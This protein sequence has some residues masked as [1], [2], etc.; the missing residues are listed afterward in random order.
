VNSKKSRKNDKIC[1]V[2]KEDIFEVVTCKN[3]TEEFLICEECETV[4]KEQESESDTESGYSS[5]E[6]PY[7]SSS[8]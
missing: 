1:P 6:C 3:C 4:F 2:C 7:C 5:L 8:I